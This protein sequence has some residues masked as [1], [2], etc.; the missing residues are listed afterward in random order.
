MPGLAVVVAFLLV[1][2]SI[3]VLVLYVHHIGRSLRV[4]A[5]IELVGKDTRTQ[6][7]AFYPQPPDAEASPGETRRVAAPMSGV[8]CHVD[9][10][11]LVARARD[12]ECSLELVP[13]LGEFTASGHRSCACETAT[14]PASPRTSPTTS[15]WVSNARSIRTWPTACACS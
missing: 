2:I 7:D 11:Q 1:L 15:S 12:A 4:S 5:L 3:A 13:A 10:D 8:V 9:F 6:L 14:P